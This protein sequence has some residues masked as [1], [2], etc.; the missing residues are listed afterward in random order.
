MP[1]NT[2]QAKITFALL[3][4]GTVLGLAGID[5]VLPAIPSLPN[6]ISGSIES[7]QLVLASFAA[8]TAIGLLVFGELGARFDQRRLLIGSL[9]LYATMSYMAGQAESIN[10]LVAIRSFQGFTSA[11]PAVFAPGIIRSMFDQRGAI[12]AIGLMGSIES[13]TPALAPV[14]GAWLLTFSDWRAS[15]Y[16]TAA[17]AL[18]LTIAITFFGGTLLSTRSQIKKQQKYQASYFSLFN[19]RE[20]MRQGLS[21]A[22]TL[23]GLLI[24]VFGAPTVII[25]SMDGDLTNFVIMQL[26]GISLFIISANLSARLVTRFGSAVMINIGSSLTAFGCLAIYLFSLFGDGDPRW[27]WLLFAPVNLGLGLRG[28]PGFYQAVVAAGENDSRGA[29]LLI[30]FIL[31]IAAAGTALV[32]P[33]I[34]Q[35]LMPLSAA[36]ATVTVGSVVILATLRSP[37]LSGPVKNGIRR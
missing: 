2:H 8:G 14:A 27:L 16:I 36:A 11:A 35:G 34:S 15:F 4:C 17:L 7:A 26:I 5:L 12:K 20:F 31:G 3:V 25:T 19:N 10:E 22:C 9:M 28:P 18:V 6:A 30:L 21:H 13:L 33:F 23:G 1:H 32:A 37:G 24:F 29:A